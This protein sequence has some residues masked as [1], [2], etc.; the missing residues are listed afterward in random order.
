[1]SRPTPERTPWAQSTVDTTDSAFLDT[2]HGQFPVS[3]IATPREAF[4]C[5][6]RAQWMDI[7]DDP[8]VEGF[9]QIPLT[10]DS[11]RFESVFVSDHGE[12][13]LH[14]GMFMAASAPLLAFLRSA[15]DQRF[16]L[17]VDGERVSGLVT[18]SDLQKLPVYSVLFGVV[19]AVETLLMEWIRRKSK[20]DD[21]AWLKHLHP[22]QLG[23]IKK[24]WEE[25]QANNLAVDRLA[26]AS[27]KHE[28][29]AA[30][31]LGLFD[32]DDDTHERLK[33]VEA[34]R[35]RVCHAIDIAPSPEHALAVPAETRNAL[36]LASWLTG[37]INDLPEE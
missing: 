18:I 16:R 3:L 12:V 22:G 35:H 17:L 2:L 7:Q 32:A 27:F 10:G 9:D 23:T 31:G 28:M 30:I 37:R 19:L 13:A 36:S 20:W 26:V 5:R 33:R 24:Y 29:T 11:G 21:D 4:V 8:E 1:M 25:A 34:L 15:D 14:E 6:P